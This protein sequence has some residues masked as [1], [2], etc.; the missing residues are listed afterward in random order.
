[1][2]ALGIVGATHGIAP[3]WACGAIAGRARTVLLRRLGEGETP[4]AGPHLGTR[5]IESAGPGDVIVVAH[6]GRTDS[7]GWGG[8]LSA[9]ASVRGVAGVVVDGACRDVAEAE[10]LGLPLYARSTTPISARGRT[11]EVASGVP[12]D[13][14]GVRVDPGDWVV[15]D[16]DGLVVI[17]DGDVDR[18]LE[19]VREVGATEAGML[20]ALRGGAP[21]SSVL[22]RRYETMLTEG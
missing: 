15:A 16:R 8:L 4:P 3:R 9:G 2:D 21:A 5:A 11:A 6:Q 7:G 12:V 14:A 19:R 18:V 20:A 22:G 1:M 13:I 10:G 17:A